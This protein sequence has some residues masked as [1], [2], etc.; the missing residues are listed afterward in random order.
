M[1]LQRN[2]YLA[3]CLQNGFIDQTGKVWVKF[4]DRPK[5]EHRTRQT[6][7]RKRS[8]Y[9]PEFNGIEDDKVEKFFNQEIR[10]AAPYG[11]S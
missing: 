5:P 2:H 10:Y 8:L 6:V 7:G 1:N 11:R 4:A 9:I 3:A